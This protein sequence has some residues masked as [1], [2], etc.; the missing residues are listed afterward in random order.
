VF[1]LPGQGK[2]VWVARQDD[3]AGQ[4]EKETP[5]GW[6]ELRVWPAGWHEMLWL[7]GWNELL[8]LAGRG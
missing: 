5:S 2:L 8:W 6:L 7:V 3:L 1:Q 4:L